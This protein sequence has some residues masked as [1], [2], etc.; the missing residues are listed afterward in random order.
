MPRQFNGFD[1]GVAGKVREW[2]GQ[3]YRDDL[4]AVA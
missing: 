4:T 2:R 1:H 3:R